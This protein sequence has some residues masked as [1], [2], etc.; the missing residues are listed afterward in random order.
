MSAAESENANDA[1]DATTATTATPVPE[2]ARALTDVVRAFENADVAAMNAALDAADPELL[3]RVPEV[4]AAEVID[5]D[6]DYDVDDAFFGVNDY[7]LDDYDH[8]RGHMPLNL[9]ACATYALT[10]GRF[11]D[12]EW[13]TKHT[14]DAWIAVYT[15]LV[16]HPKVN[17]NAATEYEDHVEHSAQ[18]QVEVKAIVAGMDPKDVTFQSS[19]SY[20]IDDCLTPLDYC[21]TN[22]QER[23]QRLP[24]DAVQTNAPS[25]WVGVLRALLSSGRVDVK[26]DH[27]WYNNDSYVNDGTP[28]KA[29]CNLR[30]MNVVRTVLDTYDVAVVNPP[31]LMRQIKEAAAHT[32]SQSRTQE[33]VQ[34]EGNHLEQLIA[35]F[36]KRLG[37]EIRKKLLTKFIPRVA[38]AHILLARWSADARLK[39]YAP[40]GAGA[41]R[42]RTS[43]DATAA[44]AGW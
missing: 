29:I 43:F 25:R 34:Y 3:N 33:E 18:L 8:E 31:G 5:F 22:L 17:V 26:R 16:N 24:Y 37:K 30:L 11:D 23:L 13:I 6:P 12:H 7:Q 15:A 36:R 10:A 32:T 27:R 44:A 28:L 1:N 21:I 35:A 14:T 39:A 42:A 9:F 19:D 20:I 2:L 41:K 4:K 40:D 38:R